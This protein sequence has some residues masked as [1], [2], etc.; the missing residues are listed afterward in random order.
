[1]RLDDKRF[2]SSTSLAI[3]CID[4]F[5]SIP[6]EQFKVYESFQRSI[7]HVLRTRDDLH[8]VIVDHLHS[9]VDGDHPF[10]DAG[11]SLVDTSDS[12]IN[13]SDSLVDTNDSII[14][15]SD[16]IIDTSHSIIDGLHRIRNSFHSLVNIMRHLQ[17]LGSRHPSFFL[18]QIV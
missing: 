7:E 5:A 17:I 12:L 16:S 14:D 11:H 9:V 1:M 4:T 8:E 13:T 10:V 18:S 15:T 2:T 3:C 6:S